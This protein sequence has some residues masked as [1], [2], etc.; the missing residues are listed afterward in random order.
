[1]IKYSWYNFQPLKEN[2]LKKCFCTLCFHPNR[3]RCPKNWFFLRHILLGS[4]RKN[5]KT[6]FFMNRI[7][8]AENGYPVKTVQS[9]DRKKNT[10]FS[11]SKIPRV[12]AIKFRWFH[13]EWDSSTRKKINFYCFQCLKNDFFT[14]LCLRENN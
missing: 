11:E 8:I 5:K 7:P 4:F 9:V 6:T 2:L 14:G 1:M 13:R 12:F 3:S 10:I